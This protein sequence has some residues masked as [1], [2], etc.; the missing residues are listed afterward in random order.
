[1]NLTQDLINLRNQLVANH[2]DDIKATMKQ[3]TQDLL[4]E[5]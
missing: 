5:N 3:A 1:M 4:A 2:S